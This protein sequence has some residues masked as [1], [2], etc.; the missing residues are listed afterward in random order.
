MPP[1]LVAH[2]FAGTP[3]EHAAFDF[4]ADVGATAYFPGVRIEVEGRAGV[5]VD[6]RVTTTGEEVAD[7]RALDVPEHVVLAAEAS[8]PE[9]LVVC[10]D[11]ENPEP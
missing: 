10:F 4:V 3:A 2:P 6:L 7:L 8:D 11:D 9:G 5:L 1:A